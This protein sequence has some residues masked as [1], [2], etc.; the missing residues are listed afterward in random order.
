MFNQKT[1][2]SFR[3]KK[4]VNKEVKLAVR[5]A[6]KVYK[7]KTESKF[8][9]SSLC[10]SYLEGNQEHGFY[11]SLMGA[12][13]SAIFCREKRQNVCRDTSMFATIKPL[14]RQARVCQVYFCR[15]KRRVKACTSSL[16]S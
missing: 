10:T 5:K 2:V 7:T 16:A 14:S 4:Q 3:E 13:T 6:K 9:G 15:D 12:A 8:A 1:G 11:L